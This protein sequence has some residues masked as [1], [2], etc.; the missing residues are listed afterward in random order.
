MERKRNNWTYKCKK[1]TVHAH[2]SHSQS[3]ISNLT[4]IVPTL[5]SSS[6]PESRDQTPPTT[7]AKTSSASQAS[8]SS[9]QA[10]PTPSKTTPQSS[11]TAT[12]GRISMKMS[13]F[14]LHKGAT[15]LDEN[16]A[17][18]TTSLLT[19]S[20]STVSLSATPTLTSHA[21]ST[22]NTSKAVKILTSKCLE[23]WIIN[24]YVHTRHLYFT[25]A[26]FHILLYCFRFE[27]SMGSLFVLS[28]S[29]P[30]SLDFPSLP[31]LTFKCCIHFLSLC[32]CVCGHFFICMCTIVSVVLWCYGD[33]M[34]NNIWAM[35]RW[36]R[37]RERKREIIGYIMS[38]S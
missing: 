25:I 23:I 28:H 38:T 29:L 13:S 35:L 3:K 33:I 22:K 12:K 16:E 5:S 30:L 21:H 17:T 14:F 1:G 26:I 20:T 2:Y 18:P 32:V 27:A 9:L 37:E 11:S 6:L 31:S 34:V 24:E 4:K 10:T 7:S 19:Q 8:T 36:E 15:S